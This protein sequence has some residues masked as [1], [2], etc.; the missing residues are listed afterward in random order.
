MSNGIDVLR[1]K[2]QIEAAFGEVAYPGD[3][4]FESFSS[5]W[6]R[7]RPVLTGRDWRQL[8][9]DLIIDYAPLSSG[10]FPMTPQ[11]FQYFLPGYL[12]I[13]LDN[14][15]DGGVAHIEEHLHTIF[16]PIPGQKWSMDRLDPLTPAQLSAVIEF[17]SFRLAD[18]RR[19]AEKCGIVSPSGENFERCIEFIS[20]LLEQKQ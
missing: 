1:L 2:R 12:W 3:D 6:D 14:P 19:N 5:E 11:A 9:A 15:N 13:C 7:L 4:I 16:N 8:P 20:K 17:L 18:V 10:L